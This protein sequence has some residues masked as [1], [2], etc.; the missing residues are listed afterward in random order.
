VNNFTEENL[1]ENCPHCNSRSFA[2]ERPLKETQNF[3]IVCDVHPLIEG[4]VLII[5]KKHV[6]CIGEY[7]DHIY[8]EF[9]LLLDA[10][11]GFIKTTYGSVSTFEHGNVGQTVFHSHVH[12][13]PFSG[14]PL[15]IIPEG[16]TYFTLFDDFLLLR[17][18]FEKEGKYLY[19]SIEGKKW[20]VKTGLGFPRFFRDRF[21][22]A[23]KVPQRGNWKKMHENFQVM[24]KASQEIKDLQRKWNQ[25][26]ASC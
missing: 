13:L 3:W 7:P 1:I 12:L 17:S 9:L 10:F 20:S 22:H 23:L 21:A 16:K 6:S 25:S 8:Q 4:H 5:P 11:S 2:L 24:E 18:L 26:T 14:S 19:F 15:E